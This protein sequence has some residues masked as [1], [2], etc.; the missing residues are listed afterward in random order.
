MG[1]H[2]I[3]ESDFDCLTEMISRQRFIQ[4]MPKAVNLIRKSVSEPTHSK[5]MANIVSPQVAPAVTHLTNAL[6]YN[7]PGGKHARG[8][9]A[10]N[11]FSS[12]A[13]DSV[14]PDSALII[15]WAVEALQTCFLVAD[16]IMDGSETR[17]GKNCWY[18]LDN[19]GLTAINDSLSIESCVYSLLRS[20]PS[21]LPV[22]DLVSLFHEVTQVTEMGQTLDM[23]NSEL[24]MVDLDRFTDENYSGFGLPIL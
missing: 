6:Q 10:A 5:F 16:D 4:F 19:V 13:D 3:F 12:L 20:L 18:K 17:R 15:G 21:N 22:D 2:P 24:A 1:T 23:Q 14:D 11:V 7:L 9:L 8:L